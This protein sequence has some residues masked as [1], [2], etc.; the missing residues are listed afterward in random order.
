MERAL[1]SAVTGP[2]RQPSHGAGEAEREAVQAGDRSSTGQSGWRSARHDFS[3]VRVYADDEAAL[4]AASLR[5]SAYTTGTDIVFGRDRYQ[6]ATLEGRRLLAHEL[7]HVLQQSGGQPVIQRQPAVEPATE[8]R[9]ERLR[10]DP[11]LRSAYHNR[12]AMREGEVDDGVRTLQRALRDLGYPMPISF[13]RTGDADGIFG[14]ETRE[15]VR[16]FQRD[17]RLT[18]VDGVA[19]HETL[20]RLDELSGPGP[21]PPARSAV[22]LRSVRFR[23]DHGVMTDR[24]TD[25]ERGGTPYPK[26]E[27]SDATPG[28]PAAPVSHTRNRSVEIEAT[29]DVSAEGD[30]TSFQLE[31]VS[32]LGFLS[33]RGSGRL[34]PGRQVVAMRSN[35]PTPN[36]ITRAADSID[37]QL[38]TGSGRLSLATSPGHELFVTMNVPLEP[39]EVTYK[40]M[41]KA[42]EL[43][44]RVGTLVPHDL[45]RGLMDNFGRYNLH[46]QLENP[47]TLADDLERGAQCIDIVRFV[48]GIL[49]MV[50]CPGLAEAKLIWAQPATPSIAEETPTGGM[51][52]VPSPSSHPTWQACLIDG[53]ACPNNFEAVLKFTESGSTRYYPGG[54]KARFVLKEQVLGVFEFLAWIDHYDGTNYLIQQV[55]RSYRGRAVPPLPFRTACDTGRLG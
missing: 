33:F 20:G 10:S 6:P 26:P 49:N 1:T 38:V 28:V 46:V 44:G 41:A 18:M 16:R 23:S 3:R 21:S 52:T 45:V 14:P 29:T 47:W 30:G 9:S 39:G 48:Q 13:A 36:A 55:V 15:T 2:V 11:R 35:A 7:T 53:D 54:V 34:L 51:G 4:S 32:R 43:A 25:W 50:G 5:A 24:E 37:W 17:Q 8:L 27:W 22:T 31:G 12:P 19:G 42:V 40:R